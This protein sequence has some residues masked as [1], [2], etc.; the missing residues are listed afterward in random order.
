MMSRLCRD[1]AMYN[2][3]PN[4]QFARRRPA[5]CSAILSLHRRIGVTR[6]L[7]PRTRTPENSPCSA[8]YKLRR[9]SILRRIHQR[10]H[11]A[12]QRPQHRRGASRFSEAVSRGLRES[13][14]IALVVL[15][16]VLFAALGSYSADDPSFFYVGSALTIHN[17]I[18]PIGAWIADVLFSLFG[19]PAFLFPI[20]D[21]CGRLDAVSPS[22]A[23]S[24]ARAPIR[25][26]AWPVSCCCSLQ[27]A[28][29]R[30]CIGTRGSCD[31]L[32]AASSVRSS[33]RIWPPASTFLVRRCS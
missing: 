32:Q 2:A 4:L 6:G 33:A 29:S 16:L 11:E 26:C 1:F 17:R 15:A 28:R 5:R 13:A 25:R 18:G 3:A 27:A 23:A 12:W 30:R 10:E 8:G 7:S 14:V 19:R 31:K 24:S 21:R 22:K 20:D 9:I